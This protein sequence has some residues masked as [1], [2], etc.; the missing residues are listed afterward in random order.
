MHHVTHGDNVKKL[1]STI[2]RHFID[3]SDVNFA[4]HIVQ[5]LVNGKLS[6]IDNLPEQLTSV[7]HSLLTSGDAFFDDLANVNAQDY[8]QVFIPNGVR[9]LYQSKK[10]QNLCCNNGVRFFMTTDQNGLLSDQNIPRMNEKE[11]MKESTI[12]YCQQ[13]DHLL[14]QIL[15]E[16]EKYFHFEPNALVHS[17]GTTNVSLTRYY[18]TTQ[19][20]LLQLYQEDLLFIDLQDPEKVILLDE[21]FDAN[22]ITLVCYRGDTQSVEF[23]NDD[24]D[25]H[26]QYQSLDIPND[27]KLRLL[28]VPGQLL[29][30]LTSHGIKSFSHRIV[31]TPEAQKKQTLLPSQ[32]WNFT[33]GY[34]KWYRFNTITPLIQMGDS[35]KDFSQVVR[36]SELLDQ[37]MKTIFDHRDRLR[38]V[39]FPLEMAKNYPVALNYPNVF[40]QQLGEDSRIELADSVIYR[41]CV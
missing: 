15:L 29:S 25:G 1:E 2:K 12:S 17:M 16:I 13:S 21:H 37:T 19:G 5:N 30:I 7:M 31:T 33:L 34:N 26:H 9:G 38:A 41:R 14:T 23:L 11:V 24:H 8:P 18:P 4:H 39:A 32:H 36:F 28:V 3:F 40:D 27:G 35:K 22:L 6:V 10:N 20:R